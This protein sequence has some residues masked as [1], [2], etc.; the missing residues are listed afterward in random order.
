MRAAHGRSTRASPPEG[1]ARPL[2]SQ[3]LHESRDREYQP[4]RGAR[5]PGHERRTRRLIPDERAWQDEQRGKQRTGAPASGR[6]EQRVAAEDGHVH[7]RAGARRNQSARW[8]RHGHVDAHGAPAPCSL[9]GH[10]PA[11]TAQSCRTTTDG[12]RGSRTRWRSQASRARRRP[13]RAAAASPR[14]SRRVR[15]AA[16][17]E[18]RGSRTVPAPP[19]GHG[20]R[21]E[22]V[23]DP[24][25]SAS[26]SRQAAVCLVNQAAY[27]DDAHGWEG[28]TSPGPSCSIGVSAGE[29]EP[30]DGDGGPVE[31]P[32]GELGD[33]GHRGD[34]R[35]AW[36][37]APR[38][39]G[40]R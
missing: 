31:L 27:T 6:A 36:A 25:A 13:R 23:A 29:T 10:S 26:A 12:R 17:G 19:A 30:R 24:A 37:A 39:D 28:P 21:V 40:P 11:P 8:R 14:E 35:V 5:H 3:R 15:R 38:R 7:L 4:R 2:D 22:A 33:V 1:D 9:G 32:V 34:A 16:P 20:G 18:T